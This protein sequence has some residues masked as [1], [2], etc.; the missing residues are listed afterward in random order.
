[1]AVPF[2]AFIIMLRMLATLKTLFLHSFVLCYFRDSSPS[3]PALTTLLLVFLYSSFPLKSLDFFTEQ[4]AS[5][6]DCNVIR[7]LLD[8]VLRPTRA[9]VSVKCPDLR[10]VFCGA[11]TSSAERR[12]LIAAAAADEQRYAVGLVSSLLPPT[13]CWSSRLIHRKS[14]SAHVSCHVL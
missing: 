9:N 12:Q 5:Y 8:S 4:C 10:V 3:T 13:L 11:M 1:M 6:H 7:T 2:L 14:C